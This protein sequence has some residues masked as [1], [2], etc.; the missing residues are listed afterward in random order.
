MEEVCSY[1]LYQ[2]FGHLRLRL[3]PLRRDEG[4]AA[5]LTAATCIT[6]QER[7]GFR[8]QRIVTWMSCFAHTAGVRRRSRDCQCKRGEIAREAGEQH[9]SGYPSMHD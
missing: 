7:T 4:A 8:G 3:S 5:I 6:G 9:E 1:I 2:A